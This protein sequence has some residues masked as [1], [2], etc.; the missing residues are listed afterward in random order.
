VGLPDGSLDRWFSRF[1]RDAFA[2]DAA[3]IYKPFREVA[4]ATLAVL[5]AELKQPSR[6]AVV[7]DL[8]GA[9]RDLPAH[10]DVRPAFGALRDA[11]VRLATLTNGSA[12]VTHRLLQ[13]SQLETFVERIISIDEVRHR[14]PRREVY[15]HAATVTGVAPERMALIA[16]HA[17][18]VLGASRAG[19]QT[20]WVG[21]D[22]ALFHAAMGDATVRGAD[23]VE[24]VRELLTVGS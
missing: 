24:V 2:L 14:K 23:L 19:L 3:G 18:D 13:A 4:V 15:S 5:L 17:W 1:L 20:G 10:A 9:L 8:L 16:A 22:E 6:D 12:D 21:R 11:G 7:T